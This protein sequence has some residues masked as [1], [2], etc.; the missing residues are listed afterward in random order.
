MEVWGFMWGSLDIEIFSNRAKG[1]GLRTPIR[2]AR[3]GAKD[4]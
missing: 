4:H 3:N 2:M 1:H